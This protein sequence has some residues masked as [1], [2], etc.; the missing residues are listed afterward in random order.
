MS[1]RILKQIRLA[2]EQLNPSEVRA[3]AERRVRILLRASSSASYAEMEDFLSP[4]EVSRG[5]RLELAQ[6]IF[7]QDDADVPRQIDVLLVERGMPAPPGAIEFD[8]A[9]PERAVREI[10]DRDQAPGL[11]LART[12]PPFRK[13]VSER[14]I[15]T[16][17][18]ENAMF[19]IATAMP[20]V[21]PGIL[22]LPWSVPEAMS[23]TAVL[24]IN[25]IRMAFL[26]A[27]A[28]DRPIGYREQKMEVGGIVAAAFGW[29]GV[30][31]Q[32]VSKIP[33][34]G[35]IVPKAAIAYAGTYVE[36]M[37][38]ERMYSRGYGLTRNERSLAYGSALER[39]RTVVEA[40]LEAYRE[41]RGTA[42]LRQ[43]MSRAAGD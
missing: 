1:T 19:S 13:P 39:G 2:V 33:F 7:R 12:F 5:R 25:Q 38:L 6:C 22:T 16:V 27:A 8:L 26:L 15:A 28:S 23:D 24:T 10:L 40:F 31:R 35:G 18:K 4:R 3:S 32:L 14:I 43:S 21:F 36:G 11:A 42:L 9:D 17:S 30:A 20:N 37:S 34:G 29:R 41:K